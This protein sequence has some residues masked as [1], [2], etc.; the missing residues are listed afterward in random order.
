MT[1]EI[2]GKYKKNLTTPSDIESW[3]INDVLLKQNETVLDNLIFI[4]NSIKRDDSHNDNNIV[5][6]PILSNTTF[7]GIFTQLKEI[8][9]MIDTI[10][11]VLTKK[12]TSKDEYRNGIIEINKILDS[13]I[14]VFNNED[15]DTVDIVLDSNLTIQIYLIKDSMVIKFKLKNSLVTIGYINDPFVINLYSK[16]IHLKDNIKLLAW[17][18]NQ[19]KSI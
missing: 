8:Y 13:I 10:S 16:I 3:Y 4:I 9:G 18:F 15:R 1:T 14:K 17:N 19:I 5:N 2:Y 11:T 12:Y 7:K 6:I